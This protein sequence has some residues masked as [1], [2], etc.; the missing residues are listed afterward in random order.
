MTQDQ[1][2]ALIG[3]ITRPIAGRKLDAT[4]E[5]DLNRMFPFGGETVRSV[6]AECN[7]A[8]A[9]GWMCGREHQRIKF[10]RVIA[11]GPESDGFSV[12]VVEMDECAG[13]HHRHPTG[14]IDLVMPVRG[15]AKFDGRGA[16]WLVYEAG[17]AQAGGE[18]RCRR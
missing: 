8:I 17:S 5:A 9:E 1:F 13:G 11:P 7:G 10:G 16:G 3:T 12:D 15:P 18:G 2:A 6:F 14:E 4:L